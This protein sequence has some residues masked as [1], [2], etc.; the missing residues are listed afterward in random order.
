MLS[1]TGAV[2]S[3]LEEDPRK[4]R[5]INDMMSISLRAGGYHN[6]GDDRYDDDDDDD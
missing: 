3:E 5:K 6:G 4:R 2:K 1:K